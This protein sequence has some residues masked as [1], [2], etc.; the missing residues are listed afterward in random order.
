[1]VTELNL[2]RQQNTKPSL[3]YLHRIR[4]CH[5]LNGGSQHS[6]ITFGFQSFDYSQ[7]WCWVLWLSGAAV[8]IDTDNKMWL[9][10]I[11][12]NAAKI[13]TTIITTMPNN[14]TTRI[15]AHI[16]LWIA[17]LTSGFTSKIWHHLNLSKKIIGRNSYWSINSYVAKYH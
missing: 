17:A 5:H 14:D 12:Y 8:I 3:S 6:L 4:R 1:M 10:M 13:M 9:Q 11:A 7:S 2:A 16:K 15:K